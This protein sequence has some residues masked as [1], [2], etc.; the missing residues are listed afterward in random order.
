MPSSPAVSLAC[1]DGGAWRAAWAVLHGLAVASLAAWLVHPAGAL[2]WLPVMALAWWWMPPSGPLRLAWDGQAWQLDGRAGRVRVALDLGG[3][4]LL[5]FRADQR[6]DAAVQGDAGGAARDGW[7]PLSPA[8]GAWAPMRAALYAAAG[9]ASERP[10][11]A[12]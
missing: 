2:L 10:S 9:P 8:A 3:W 4:M 11:V 6:A 5:H 1:R 7:L 12:P